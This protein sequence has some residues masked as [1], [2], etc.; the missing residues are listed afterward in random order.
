M[1]PD[2]ITAHGKTAWSFGKTDTHRQKSLSFLY[3]NRFSKEAIIENHVRL[4]LRIR[5]D[6]CNKMYLVQDPHQ[7]SS[8][9]PCILHIFRTRKVHG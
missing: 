4:I 8:F 5:I 7:V 3:S 6:L 1:V 2:Q 9:P